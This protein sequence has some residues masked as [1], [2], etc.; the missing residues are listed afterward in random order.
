MWVERYRERERERERVVE[1]YECVFSAQAKLAQ[2]YCACSGLII[3]FIHIFLRE[4]F[5]FS[6]FFSLLQNR[7]VSPDKLTRN[8]FK[9]ELDFDEISEVY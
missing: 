1:G 6:C 7:T 5:F 8:L 3:S 9:L 4:L 2:T